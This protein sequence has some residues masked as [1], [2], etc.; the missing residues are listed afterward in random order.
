MLTRIRSKDDKT[1]VAGSGIKMTLRK[2]GGFISGTNRVAFRPLT[3]SPTSPKFPRNTNFACTTRATVQ[4]RMRKIVDPSG[5]NAQ[6]V[7]TSNL[8]YR[9]HSWVRDPLRYKRRVQVH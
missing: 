9:A 8:A 7:H 3:H 5:H 6:L 4:M 2:T 1:F